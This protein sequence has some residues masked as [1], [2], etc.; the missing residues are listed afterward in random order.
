[1]AATKADRAVKRGE[2]RQAR[3]KRKGAMAAQ[4]QMA[5]E[6]DKV[7]EVAPEKETKK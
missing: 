4:A 3:A 1:M 2:E 6:S 7:Q 5:A